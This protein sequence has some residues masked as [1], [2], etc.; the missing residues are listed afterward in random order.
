[1]DDN[2]YSSPTPADASHPQGAVVAYRI[3][4]T[5]AVSFKL[6]RDTSRDDVRREAQ[7][8]IQNEIG[9]ENVISITE[10]AGSFEGFSVVI[11]YRVKSS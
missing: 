1:M 10:H 3:F 8:A 2:P 9:A 6:T 11:W 5:R 7:E 4:G